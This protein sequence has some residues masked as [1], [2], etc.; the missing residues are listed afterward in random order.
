MTDVPTVR[1]AGKDWPIP[2]LGIKQNRVV[3]PAFLKFMPAFV[4]IASAVASKDKDPMWFLS[5]SITTEDMDNI[6]D[7]IYGSLLKATPGLARNEFDNLAISME[8]LFEAIPVIAM[9]TGILKPKAVGAE[10][11]PVGEPPATAESTSISSSPITAQA[12]ASPGPTS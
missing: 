7:A 4:K 10:E 3:I 2:V 9:Q 11:A 8:E 1:L 12:P 6:C 5:L